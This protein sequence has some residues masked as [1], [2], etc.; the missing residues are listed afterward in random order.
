MRVASVF[1]TMF[2]V[3]LSYVVS[4]RNIA[5]KIKQRH[6]LETLMIREHNLKYNE[7]HV[8]FIRTQQQI[9]LRFHYDYVR[10]S[11]VADDEG[12]QRVCHYA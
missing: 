2:K 6:Y 12:T 9:E 10:F 5:S 1:F 11:S 8:G 4:F 7:K 3:M